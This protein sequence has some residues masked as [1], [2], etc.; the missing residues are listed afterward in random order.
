MPFFILFDSNKKRV[1]IKDGSDELE[2]IKRAL[3][4]IK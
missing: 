4:E 1:F 2:N 3:A